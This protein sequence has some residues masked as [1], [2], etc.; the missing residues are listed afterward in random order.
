MVDEKQRQIEDKWQKKWKENKTFEPKINK[1]QDKYLGN[2]AYPY[3]NSVLHI[4]HGRTYTIADVY[5]RYQRLLGKN[6]LQP[7]G[8]HISGTPVLAVA[9][10]IKRGDEKTIKQVRDAIS[11]YITDKKEQDKIIQ[12]FTEPKNIADFFSGK[13]EGALDSV[14]MSIDWSRKFSTGEDIYNK[15]IEW[16]YSKLKDAGLLKQGKYPILYSAQDENAVGE[17]D[18]K[19]GDTDKVTI[20]EMK[21]IKF[22]LTDTQEYVVAATLRPDSLF[23]ATN[24][25]IKPE[26]DLVKL[27]VEGDVWIVA[28]KAQVKVEHQF[29]NVKFIEEL[30]GED[31]IN[32]EVEVPIIDKTVPIYKADFCDENHGTG[33]VYS[34]PADSVHDYLYLFETLHPGKN[35]E[36]F[37]S[38]EPL[39]LIPITKTFDKKGKEVEYKFNIPAYHKLFEY[40]IFKSKGNLDKLEQIKQEL[41][42]EAHFGAIMINCGEFD[43][44]PLKGEVGAKKVL[45]KLESLNL[46][47]IFYETSRRAQTRG[48]DNVIVANLHGQWFLDYSDRQVK[49]KAQELLRDAKF[50]P[51]NLRQAQEGYIEWANMRPCARKRGLG[52][53]IPYDK[54]WIIEPLS[55]STIYQMLYMISPLIRKYNI[56]PEELT[57]EVFDYLYLNKAVP[58]SNISKEFLKEA[59]EQV[60]YWNNVDFRY[61]GMPHMSNHLNF[62]IYH[63]SLI[64][65]N[66]MWPKMIVTGNLMMKDGEKIS[67][68]KGNGTPLYRMKNIYSADLYR[69][70]IATNS[71]FDVEMDFKDNEIF[72]LEKKFDKWKSLIEESISKK[73]KSYEQFSNTNKWLISKF[74][75]RAKEYLNYFEEFR[76]REAFVTILYEFLNEVNYHERRTSLDETL[77]VIRFIAHDYIKLMTPVTP[78]I[79]EE[80]NEKLGEKTEVSLQAFTTD[81]DKYVNK[82]A[83]KEEGIIE[84]LLVKIISQKERQN[85][86][87]LNKITIVQAQNLRFELFEL[88]NKK[89]KETREFKELL[90]AINKENKFKDDMKFIQKFLPKTLK[91]GLTTYIGLEKETETLN[92]VKSFLKQ[93][94]NCEIEIVSNDDLENKSNAIPGEPGVIIE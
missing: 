38:E 82:E 44:T 57:F 42:K 3:A 85:I 45:E 26:M 54:D 6:V 5:L 2:V 22:K 65:P 53:R 43:N 66:S 36:D 70:Y 29:D 68:S 16:Q 62:L 15:F 73:A 52:T 92:E 94:F 84:E 25:Y 67:K 55:D 40:K 50:Y 8:F 56:E 83:Q 18:I 78:H 80:L 91:E 4:G 64:F 24:M 61:V 63:Y 76:I 47:G 51:T 7:L 72:Q 28:K 81:C 46:G 41:Y 93:E 10:G 9:D 39:K 79:C 19:D 49:D 14:G 69:L 35:L 32:K 1:N 58:K 27:K 87:K 48:N 12:T 75:S 13:I 59:K 11:D 88:L 21:Y 23:G 86:E 30:K 90:D 71:N 34:S 33:I 37:T 20:Q 74:Y 60:Q 89:L 77:E 31:L 17:D